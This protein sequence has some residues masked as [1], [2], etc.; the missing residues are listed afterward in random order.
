MIDVNCRCIVSLMEDKGHKAEC[1]YAPKDLR[2][3]QV[4]YIQR[5][6]NFWGTLIGKPVFLKY[7]F[8][9]RYGEAIIDDYA[10]VIGVQGGGLGYSG[11]V[12]VFL[13]PLFKDSK[14]PGVAIINNLE[15]INT[16]EECVIHLMRLTRTPKRR[17]DL[18]V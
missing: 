9:A 2:K 5:K 7:F 6:A 1:S 15:Y 12:M 3:E 17:L 18:D 14:L 16:I 10:R 11:E 4:E 13:S 8:P